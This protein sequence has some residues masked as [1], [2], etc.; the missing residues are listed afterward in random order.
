MELRSLALEALL[1]S[2]PEAKLTAIKVLIGSRGL[3]V[4]PARILDSPLLPG[5][6]VR[7]VMVH[8]VQVPKRR[9]GTALGRAALIHALCHIEFNATN[10]ALDAIARYAGLPVAYYRDWLQALSRHPPA[11]FAWLQS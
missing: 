11:W 8:P 7:P 9:L 4:D 6:P 10:L 5:R 2:D 1:A 3:R